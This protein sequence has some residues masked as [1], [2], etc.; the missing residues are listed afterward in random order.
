MSSAAEE[1][2][3]LGRRIE[4]I[5]AA[6][7]TIRAPLIR[8]VRPVLRRVGYQPKVS[9]NAIRVLCEALRVMSAERA[10]EQMDMKRLVRHAVDELD[11][12]VTSVERTV[13]VNRSVPVAHAAWLRRL[14]ETVVRAE[15]AS[16]G[17]G[18]RTEMRIAGRD[19]SAVLFPPLVVKGSEAEPDGSEKADESA[20]LGF[21]L[22]AIDHLLDSAH[23]E[24]EV[25]ERRRRLLEAARQLL[26]ETS[27]A[28]PLDHEGVAGRMRAISREITWIDRL[29]AAGVRMDTGLLHQARTAVSRGERQRLFALLAA[30]DRC[31][32]AAGDLETAERTEAAIRALDPQG[33]AKT[34]AAM[35]ESVSRSGVE[36]FGNEIGKAIDLGYEQGRSNLGGVANKFVEGLLAKY[37]APGAERSTIAASLAVDGCFDVGGALSPVRVNED[38]VRLE[39]VPFPTP[40]LIL[41]PAVGPEDVPG[42]VIDDPRSVLLSLAEG[43]LLTRRFVHQ[44]VHTR[45]RTVLR[46]E[47]RIYVLDGSGSMIG[48]RARMRDSI[49]IAELATVARR[50]SDAARTGRVILFYRYFS[51][52]VG[53]VTRV[54]SPD[55]ALAEITNILA[56]HRSG[57]TELQKALLASLEQVR[58]AKIADPDLARAQIVLITDGNAAVSEGVIREARENAGDLPVG[59]SVIALGEENPALREIVARQRARGERA[60]Y[61][62]LDDDTLASIA[63]GQVDDAPAIH[64]PSVAIDRDASP[65]QEADALESSV[66]GLLDELG[67]LGRGRDLAAMERLEKNQLLVRTDRPLL[68]TEGEGER[69]RVES[70]QRD[71]RA[72]D[73]RFRRWFP[74]PSDA[75]LTPPP[76]DDTLERHDLESVVV[77]L[78][79]I[80]EVV[81]LVEGTEL[82]RQADAIDL[83]ERLLPDARLSPARYEAV[84]AGWPSHTKGALDA[85]HRAVRHGILRKIRD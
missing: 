66:G 35:A 18:R 59:I 60:F 5:V 85:V 6:P 31:A 28:L 76:E 2:G 25:L 62:F 61:H 4:R 19:D 7:E 37:L 11:G 32:V 26:L 16:S 30:I 13:V 38:E 49:L 27:A 84:L 57:G 74:L 55:S 36:V 33:H 78:A 23:E 70:A 81:G 64:L 34:T 41:V 52:D 71:R 80:T 83:L 82:A 54:D 53:P 68:V 79:T 15:A 29:Q 17:R 14:Y 48:P 46:G 39:Q 21:Q 45:T 69:A 47:V 72:L 77:L 50:M 75:P 51:D 8:L 65:Q 1:L 58:E 24:R 42:A 40:K 67:G 63:A 12:N 56:T 20:L 10:P 22:G 3:D 9:V 44:R 43:K 73:F